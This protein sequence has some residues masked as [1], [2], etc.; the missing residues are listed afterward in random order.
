MASL[1]NS[2]L[3]NVILDL[4][5]A[6]TYQNFIE[7]GTYLGE[8]AVWAAAHF[9]K[10]ITI[11]LSSDLYEAAL[12]NLKDLRNVTILQG[13]SGKLLGEVVSHLEGR[14][15]FWLDGHYS[16]GM[17]AG[18][19]RECPVLDELSGLRGCGPDDI[20]LIDD[21]HMFLVP[22]PPPHRAEHWPNLV[23]VFD[24]LRLINPAF[25][26][27][28]ADN[29]IICVP[30]Q[31]RQ[32]LLDR[33][34]QNELTDEKE[35]SPS[36]PH[37]TIFVA[38]GL[39]TPPDAL[40]L[41]LGCGETH[42]EGYVNID[43]PA[44]QH[45]LMHPKA[46]FSADILKLV[47]SDGVVSEIRLHHVFEHFNRVTALAMLIR[48]HRWLKIGG[49]IRIKT[50]D[51]MGSARMLP[52]DVSLLTRMGI[53]RHLAGDQSSEWGYH[54]DHWFP[55]RFEHTL[56]LLGFGEIQSR[57]SQWEEEPFLSNVEVIGLKRED[58]SLEEQLGIAD[59]LLWESTVADAEKATHEVWR[60]Q[61][62]D[63]WGV[64]Y[65]PGFVSAAG[66]RKAGPVVPKEASPG[67]PAISSPPFDFA[68]I[69]K[70]G[71]SQLPIEEIHDFNQSDRNLWVRTKARSL[72][73]GS[74]VLD[75]GAGTCLYREDFA[76]CIYETQDFM[77]YDGYRDDR[78]GLYG[79]IDYVSDIKAI[80][81]PSESFDAILCT[82]VLEHVPE[83]IE[84][85][86]EMSRILKAGGRL[87]V[88][89]P[90]GSGL[91][92][93][94]YHFYGGFTPSWYRYFFEKVGLTVL[95]IAPNG[96]FFKLLAQECARVAW[97]MPQHE[98]LH[99]DNKE[100]V[101]TLFG[102]LL[103][104]FLFALDEKFPIDQ[105]TVGYHVEAVKIKAG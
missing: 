40:K 45:S 91:H 52:G 53:V 24:A 102:V 38:N 95:E 42:L 9:E 44:T 92:Q 83:P 59:E 7:T 86:R 22:P 97:T 13:D 5:C 72:A 4:K 105:F 82:E 47:F 39:W 18:E 66:D 58:R 81:V 55:E 80:P 56:G 93:L 49:T 12:N 57:T 31:L 69:L 77:Q 29:V 15:I 75:V 35:A 11:E 88:T 14:S 30:E 16:F 2:D 98:H 50:P 10:V 63:F 33:L 28:V 76:H 64:S 100:A 1:S 20:I 74:R 48:W 23:R 104:Q 68:K 94:P 84:A 26:P 25:F 17:T 70:Q 32:R 6:G 36:A 43:Y 96:G 19:E 85:L 78:E 103:P 34:R 99:G 67:T 51:I 79:R 41:H 60:K 65:E 61:L 71:A 3:S 46:D 62:R 101:G 73:P 8:T 21:A 27:V 90:L 37:D 54:V 89:A 87:F